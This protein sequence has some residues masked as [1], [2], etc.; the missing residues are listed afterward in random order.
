MRFP[1]LVFTVILFVSAAGLGANA[2]GQA[3]GGGPHG[4]PPPGSPGATSMGSPSGPPSAGNSS[5]SASAAHATTSGAAHS[6]V[7]F[8]PVGRWWDDKSVVKSVGLSQDQQKKMDGIFDANKSAIVGSYKT[9]LSEQAKLEKINKDP[10]SDQ[11]TVFAAIDSVSKARAALQKATAQM[12]L[13][14]KQ[15]MDPSQISKLEKLQ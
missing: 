5:T 15:Q 9:F 13:Q 3:P 14:I 7:Q 10:H 11:A 2:R 8:G 12:L 6:S 1:R 4:G